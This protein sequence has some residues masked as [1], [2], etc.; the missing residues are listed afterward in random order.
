[1]DLEYIN[2]ALCKSGQ[3]N[4]LIS[5]DKYCYVQCKDC[6]LVY[7]NPRPSKDFL[8]DM[9]R[10]DEHH[11]MDPR[12]RPTEEEDL[13][14]NRFSERL[15]DINRLRQKKGRILDIGSAWGYFL[16]LAKKDDWDAYGVELF[17]LPGDILRRDSI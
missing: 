13:Y 11:L 16:S 4:K 12:K 9:Y 8:L 7:L 1:M 15:K 5:I 3:A 2:C 14:I 6:G 10:G 17:L